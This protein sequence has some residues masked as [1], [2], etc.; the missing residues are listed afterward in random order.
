MSNKITIENLKQENFA[1]NEFLNSDTATRLKI[2]NTPNQA[3]LKNGVHLAKKMQELHNILS[4][5]LKEKVT[6]IISSGFRNE[7]VNKAV[8][9]SPNSKHMQFLACDFNLKGRTPEQTVSLIKACKFVV[10][11]C[12]IERD[13]VHIQF[14]LEDAKNENLFGYA[15][16]INGVWKVTKWLK[17]N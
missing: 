9:G 13:C 6:I 7:A 11:R 14:E 10:D 15:E 4:D 1:P 2:K 8:G 12:F 16:R 5:H 3:Q 17:S